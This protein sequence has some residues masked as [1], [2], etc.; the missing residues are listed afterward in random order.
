MLKKKNTQKN[1]ETPKTKTKKQDP[2]VGGLVMGD[3][4]QYRYQD[5]GNIMSSL[6][7]LRQKTPHSSIKHL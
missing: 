4:F 6:S 1:S 7:Y 2:M 3:F 5:Y